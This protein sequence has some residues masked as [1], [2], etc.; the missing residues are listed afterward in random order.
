MYLYQEFYF[1]ITSRSQK[2]MID[3]CSAVQTSIHIA[4]CLK[5]RFWVDFKIESVL[6]LIITSEGHGKQN[7]I[8]IDSYEEMGAATVDSR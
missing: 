3:F 4:L 5:Y 6:F 2:Y 1:K 8:M 7:F